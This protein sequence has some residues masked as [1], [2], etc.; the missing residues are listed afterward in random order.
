V[1]FKKIIIIEIA[2]AQ[3]PEQRM[4]AKPPFVQLLFK[5]NLTIIF[6]KPAVQQMQVYN[7]AFIF[8]AKRYAVINSLLKNLPNY[9]AILHKMMV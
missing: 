4:Y 9:S 5:E 8:L 6:W 2:T 1:K 7:W 3:F